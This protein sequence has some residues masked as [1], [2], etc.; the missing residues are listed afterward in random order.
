MPKRIAPKTFDKITEYKPPIVLIPNK[1]SLDNE[2]DKHNGEQ[3]Q[4][5]G[6]K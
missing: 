2:H 3:D 6:N 4:S 5:E 1:D